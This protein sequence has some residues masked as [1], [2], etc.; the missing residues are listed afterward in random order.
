MKFLRLEQESNGT[1]QKVFINIEHISSIEPCWHNQDYS[2]IYL[3]NR[4]CI[5]N[6]LGKAEELIKT[7]ENYF[8]E[9]EKN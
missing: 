7:V 4:T 8:D 5:Y 1:T 6:V 9:L 3:F 2:N